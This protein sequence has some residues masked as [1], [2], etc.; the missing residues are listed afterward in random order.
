MSDELV[1]GIAC[2]WMPG[3]AE[4]TW[5][6]LFAHLCTKLNSGELHRIT[7]SV[8]RLPLSLLFTV[9]AGTAE[10]DSNRVYAE[11]PIEIRRTARSVSCGECLQ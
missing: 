1:V 10:L 2:C 4:Q 11:Q 6:G 3:R 7:D 5:A 9:R 8:E